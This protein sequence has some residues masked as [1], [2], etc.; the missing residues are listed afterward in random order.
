MELADAGD[1][2]DMAAAVIPP[3]A[4]DH[5][6]AEENTA[7]AVTATANPAI[8]ARHRLPAL[9][10]PEPPV[11]SDLPTGT[12]ISRK[13]MRVRLPGCGLAPFISAA[14]AGHRRASGA[15]R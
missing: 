14:P 11:T 4:A 5:P 7:A 1:A 10:I 8:T 3:P 6:P 12:V 15:I 13:H 9:V 2:A